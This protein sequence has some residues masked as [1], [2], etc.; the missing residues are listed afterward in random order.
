MYYLYVKIQNKTGLKYLG[1]TTQDPQKYRGSGKRWLNHINFHGNDITTL[2]LLETNDK[3]LL[4]QKAKYYST[5]WNIVNDESWANLVEEL[6]DGGDTSKFIDYDNTDQ[7]FRN[8]EEY[9]SKLSKTQR[10]KWNYKFSD[11]NFDYDAYKKMC[12]E[13]STK[14]WK[15]RGISKDECLQRAKIAKQNYIKDPTLRKRVSESTMKAWDNNPIYYE[16]THPTGFKQKVKFLRRWCK[17][18]KINYHTL[19]GTIRRKK[20]SRD[21]WF[22]KK[23]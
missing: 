1:K 7:S 20:P 21:G 16:V 5:L 13:R 6:G 2:I 8:N 15:E 12:S 4:K 18:N 17:E 3:S 11:K 23:I 14:M 22:V 19:Y 10:N 9:I